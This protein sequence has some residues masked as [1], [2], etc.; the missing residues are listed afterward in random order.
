MPF[1]SSSSSSGYVEIVFVL[2]LGARRDVGG[3]P[4]LHPR[5]AKVVGLVGADRREPQTDVTRARQRERGGL[6]GWR[7]DRG[8]VGFVCVLKRER[9]RIARIEDV[10]F[11]E[12]GERDLHRVELAEAVLVDRRMRI[13]SRRPDLHRHDEMRH[14]GIVDAN[15]AAVVARGR[16][17]GN[18]R[19]DHRR[20]VDAREGELRIANQ[21]PPDVHAS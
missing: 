14:I 9:Q 8:D 3:E 7:I 1:S 4:F 13:V 12:V 11:V 16:G 6:V 2:R 20:I 19:S 15:G 18:Q 5:G 10:V 17:I 21:R